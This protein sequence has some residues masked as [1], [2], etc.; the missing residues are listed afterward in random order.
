M[1]NCVL[2][3][4]QSVIYLTNLILAYDPESAKKKIKAGIA[5]APKKAKTYS[6]T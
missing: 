3:L 6:S 1:K 4:P 5:I 2:V